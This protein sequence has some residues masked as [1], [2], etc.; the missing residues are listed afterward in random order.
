MLDDEMS[1]LVVVAIALLGGLAGA[2]QSQFLGEMEERVGTLASAFV[3][4]AG[5]GLAVAVLML[6]FQGSRL[7]ELRE[8]PWWVFGSGVLGLVIVAALG[9]SVS[10]L[11][12]GAGLTLF[13]AA[14]LILAAVIEHLGWFGDGRSLDAIRILG[15][16]LVI[17]GTW[18]VVRG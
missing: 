15:I 10:N 9:V 4:Y 14:S 1:L 5:G 3:T 18:M 12:L 2:L 8:L 17:G 16:G 6:V 13:T 7:S 11:G